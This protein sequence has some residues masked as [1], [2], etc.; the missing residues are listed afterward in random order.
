MALQRKIPGPTAAIE[1][2]PPIAIRP[3]GGAMVTAPPASLLRQRV[4]NKATQALLSRGSGPFKSPGGGSQ[5]VTGAAAPAART[6]ESVS[7]AQKKAGAGQPGSKPPQESQ[8]APDM[9][10][11]PA[12]AKKA[13]KTPQQDPAFQRVIGHTKKAKADLRKSQPP[14]SKKQQITDAAYLSTKEQSDYNDRKT[15]LETIN[16]TAVSHQDVKQNFT[17]AQFKSLLETHLQTLEQKLPHSEAE[18]RRFKNEKPLE[19]I[20]DNVS[21]EVKDQNQKV[22]APIT[23]ETGRAEPPKSGFQPTVAKDLMEEKAGAKPKAISPA[24][25][26]PK[27]LDDSEISLEK[28]SQSLDELMAK[29]NNTEDQFAESNEPKFKKA[30]STKKDAQAKAAAAPQQY[31]GREH[32]VLAAA[33]GKARAEGSSAF[34]SMYGTREG[35]FGGVF[36]KQKD[37]AK[38]DKTQQ[39]AVK[40]QL[41]GIYNATKT[42]VEKIFTDLSEYVDTTFNTESTTAKTAFEERVEEQLGDIHGWGVKDFLFGEDT[43]A[44]EAVF[45]REK[46]RFLTAMDRTLNTI[47]QRIADDLNKA[48]NRI[49][50]GEKDAETF[51]GNLDKEQQRLS[52]DAMDTF[53]IQFKNLETSVDEKQ[54]ELVQSLAESYKESRGS[55]RATFNKINEDVKKNWIQRAAEF[56][57][58][59][60][61]TIYRLGELLVTVLVRIANLIGDIL[62]HPIRFLENLAAGIKQGFKTFAD[63]FD[64]YLLA[65]FFDWLKGKV[66]T[67]IKLPPKFDTAGL[68]SLVL[69]VI[70]LTYDNFRRIAAD[71]LGEPTVAAFEKGVEGAQE[72]YRLFQMARNDIGA[73]WTH[74]KDVLATQVDEIFEKIKTTV[75]YETIKKVLVYIVTLFNPVGAFIKAA[76]AIYAGIRFLM[77]NID[78]IAALVNAFLDGVEMAVKGN[79][80]GIASK[81]ITGLQNAIVLGIDFLAKL[82]GLGNLDD[83]VRAIIKRLSTPVERAMGF[84]VDKVIKPAAKLVVKAGKSIL[85]WWKKRQR[86]KAGGETHEIYFTGTE[87][88]AKL[89]VASDPKLVSSFVNKAEGAIKTDD[90]N[91]SKKVAAIKAIREALDVMTKEEV[92]APEKQDK[93]AIVKAFAKVGKNLPVLMELDKADDSLVGEID[94]ERPKFSDKVRKQIVIN[95]DKEDRRHIVSSQDMAEHYEK[96]LRK[97][98]MWQAAKLLLERGQPVQKP[99]SDKVIETAAKQRHKRFFN[100][101]HNLYGGD[102]EKNR[103]LGRTI[104]PKPGMGPKKLSD[105]LEYIRGRWAL[106]PDTLIPTGM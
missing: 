36:Q 33:Q 82:L 39:A 95:A 4:G 57:K 54:T 79:V 69:Q 45:A 30:L 77:D 80:G 75:L 25:A 86:F 102:L 78:R 15:H 70:G 100:D 72:I 88:S 49:K 60:A 20:K 18:A 34:G 56:I 92:K 42:E 43:E 94:V 5:N 26:A 76:Q 31:R 66:G 12:A 96:C 14:E 85:E 98:P 89:M 73:L 11:A 91:K 46:K 9:S 71:K 84:V 21:R 50:Q 68:F 65:G 17:A 44:I 24:A 6:G 23:A 51:Y 83:K 59:V 29:N 81:V 67:S 74:I 93:N 97:K 105:H 3:P 104:D 48:V 32:Q 53:R 47:A 2:R 106:V 22:A 40:T 55:L 62:A 38:D 63:N 103:S 61:L 27:P 28:E 7:P 10:A 19:Q 35:A 1:R 58:E 41:E 37:T 99:L 8:V 52:A 101:I 64:T 16:E 87:K 13:P 90:P